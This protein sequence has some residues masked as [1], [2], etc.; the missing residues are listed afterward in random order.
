MGWSLVF[1]G[2]DPSRVSVTNAGGV[3]GALGPESEDGV[4]DSAL[5]AIDPRPTPIHKVEALLPLSLVFGRANEI[6]D[7]KMS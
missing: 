2:S 5:Q 6:M 4:Q 3:D 1:C 7:V